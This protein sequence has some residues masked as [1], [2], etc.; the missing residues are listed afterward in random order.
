MFAE[1]EI[2]YVNTNQIIYKYES[3]I[4][5]DWVMQKLISPSQTALTFSYFIDRH[6]INDEMCH[7][8]QKSKFRNLS[9]CECVWLKRDK[10]WRRVIELEIERERESNQNLR[11]ICVF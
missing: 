3:L 9:L 5:S 11:K 4:K 6:D 2:V 1:V 10:G 7:S 8:S